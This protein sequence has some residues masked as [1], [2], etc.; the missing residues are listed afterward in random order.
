MYAVIY[1]F[2]Y[3]SV[4][5]L[6]D[7][8]EDNGVDETPNCFQETCTAM[9]GGATGLEKVQDHKVDHVP[10]PGECLDDGTP[11]DDV[12]NRAL[13]ESVAEKPEGSLQSVA[14][15]LGLALEALPVDLEKDQPMQR[16][17]IYRGRKLDSVFASMGLRGICGPN[18]RQ[19]PTCKE[20][21]LQIAKLSCRQRKEEKKRKEKEQKLEA[22]LA[23]MR[24]SR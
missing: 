5:F 11:V 22:R 23:R 7:G 18:N 4:D 21:Q 16:E 14:D 10:S 9:D 24:Q 1:L 2:I 12:N 6:Y 20:Y 17:D 13:S 3:S 8:Y 19:C 15:D